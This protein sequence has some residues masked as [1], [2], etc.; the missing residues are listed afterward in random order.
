M[1]PRRAEC[2][3]ALVS[4]GAVE[5]RACSAGSSTWRGV[6]KRDTAVG[7]SAL[8]GNKAQESIGLVVAGTQQLATDS[9]REQSL[10]V[11]AWVERKK[12]SGAT[13]ILDDGSRAGS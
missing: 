1:S 12:A 13:R 11:G 9:D 3:G 5:G 7:G 4:G 2:F 10:E 8:K 6:H